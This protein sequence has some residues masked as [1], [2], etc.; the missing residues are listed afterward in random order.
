[1][2]RALEETI[3][4]WRHLWDKLETQ[5]IRNYLEFLRVTLARTPRNTGYGL[6]NKAR[7]PVEGQGHQAS[8][9]RF[10]LPARCARVK[11]AQKL[12]Q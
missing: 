11:I 7:F 10:F 6:Y 12:R 5:S 3:R 9:K 2:E 1:M 4:L 8:H